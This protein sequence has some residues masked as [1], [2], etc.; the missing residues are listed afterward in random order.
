MVDKNLLAHQQPVAWKILSRSLRS[1]RIS[2]AYLFYGPKNP[3]KSKMA[4]L[5][6]QSLVC[7][8]PDEDG[9]ACQ[10]CESCLQLE[11]E[12][13][14]DFYW[15]HPGGI[16]KSR[17]LSRK[18]LDAW[19][20]NRLEQGSSTRSWRIRKEDVLAV[21]EAFAL[22]AVTTGQKQIYILEQ[23]ES[24]TPSAS[25]SLLKFLEEPKDSLIGILTVDEL[26]SVLPTI[27][28]RCQL[29]PF[30]TPPVEGLKAEL[31]DLIEDEEIVS[32]LAKAGYDLEKAGPLLEDEAIFELRDAALAWWEQRTLHMALVNL[33][34]GV[35]S[36]NRHLSREGLAFFFQTLL[37]KLEQEQSLDLLYLDLRILLLEALDAL[38]LPLDPALLLERTLFALRRRSLQ[39]KEG[40]DKVCKRP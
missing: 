30:R 38:R 34:L 15:L 3:M 35:F 11:K 10:E 19:W 31:A 37:W 9:F 33:Q 18:E 8:N 28:S 21:Q 5:Y 7:K 40:P 16:R 4:L 13:N 24:A 32:I 1:G 6:A 27:V 20:K 23:Y 36:K 25:N 12:E 26:S 14:P 29:I 2:H 22:S 17:P 39:E